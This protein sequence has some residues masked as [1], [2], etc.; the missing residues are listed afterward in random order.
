MKVGLKNYLCMYCLEYIK[1][2]FVIFRLP[3]VSNG[4]FI[5]LCSLLHSFTHVHY[6]LEN[7]PKLWHSLNFR[8]SFY[9]NR[10]YIFRSLGFS[11]IEN[12]STL[13]RTACYTPLL[14]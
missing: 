7:K 8:T 6:D 3:L 13:D 5:S 11:L 10:S 2:R 4:K 1:I 9:K 14:S 12:V